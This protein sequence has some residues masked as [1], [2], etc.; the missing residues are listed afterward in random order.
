LL[1]PKEGGEGGGKAFSRAER[2]RH[3]SRRMK[4]GTPAFFPK[5]RREKK[6]APT[7][8]EKRRH[9]MKKKMCVNE[10]RKRKMGTIFVPSYALQKKRGPLKAIVPSCVGK[11]NQ[12]SRLFE[13][14]GKKEG[15]GKL[16]AAA[17]L[18]AES[19][20][21]PIFQNEEEKISA[22]DRERK[23]ERCQ[24]MRV[25]ELI[26]RGCKRRHL[27]RKKKSLYSFADD[28]GRGEREGKEESGEQASPPHPQKKKGKRPPS[29]Y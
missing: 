26:R 10:Q 20:A 19:G 28:E 12:R 29:F 14:G 23:K 6:T 2:P 5:G 13:G 15:E 24:R 18:P 3:F 21:S 25:P 9:A 4:E 11:K 22:P 8:G 16:I 7:S 17:I 1:E 27:E